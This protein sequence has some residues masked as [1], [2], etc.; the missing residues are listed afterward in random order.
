MFKSTTLLSNVCRVLA[1]T[2]L[3]LVMAATAKAEGYDLNRMISGGGGGGGTDPAKRKIVQSRGQYICLDVSEAPGNQVRFTLRSD[4][5]EP[6]AR[7]VSVG[8]STGRHAGLF[9]GWTVV[10]QS[11]GLKS[12]VFS[13]K[14]DLTT[15]TFGG[16]FGIE[17]PYEYSKSGKRPTGGLAP[18]HFIVMSAALGPGKTFANVVAALSEGMNPATEASGLR[19]SASAHFLLGGPPPGVG[20]I[21]DDA[22]FTLR[23]VSP[24]CRAR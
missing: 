9:T 11:P 2:A 16:R 18:G 21:H 14:F 10:H 3:A 12:T 23:G 15:R 19:I 13:P 7:L 22:T 20:T 8:L 17:F 1:G 5:P 4:I 24:R 6:N